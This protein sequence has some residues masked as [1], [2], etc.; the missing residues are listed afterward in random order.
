MKS[1]QRKRV[2]VEEAPP[3][4]AAVLDEVA[5]LFEKRFEFRVPPGETWTLPEA[6]LV[7]SSPAAQQPHADLQRLKKDLNEVKGRLSDKPLDVWHEHTAATNRTGHVVGHVRRVAG[8]ELCTQAWCKFHELLAGGL[9]V[10]PPS[11]LRRGGGRINSVHLCEAPGAFIC[12]LNHY[13]R[14]HQ[15]ACKL[16]WLA[17]TLNPFHESNTCGSM[18]PDARLILHTAARWCFG[19]DDTGDAM[20]LANLRRLQERARDELGDGAHLVTADGSFDCQGN[21]GEQEACVAPLV[22]CETVTALALLAPGGSFVLKLF[23]LFEHSSAC[24]LFL[25]V[26]TFQEVH[27]VKPATSKA[28]NSELYVVCLGFR[29]RDTFPPALLERL[30][31]HVGPDVCAHTALFPAARLPPSFTQ[32]LL[33]CATM[34]QKLQADTILENLW[35]FENDAGEERWAHIEAVREAAAWFYTD[36]YDVQPLARRDWLMQRPP[37]GSGAP[38]FQSYSGKGKQR[39]VGTYNQRKELESLSWREKVMQGYFEPDMRTFD[40]L[41]KID[42]PSRDAAREGECDGADERSEDPAE[43]RVL[44]CSPDPPDES[45]FSVRHGPAL[46]RV[47]NSPFCDVKLLERLNEARAKAAVVRPANAVWLSGQHREGSQSAAETEQRVR[48]T[49]IKLLNGK[50]LRGVYYMDIGQQTRRASVGQTLC[51]QLNPMDDVIDNSRKNKS[52]STDESSASA[53]VHS[54]QPDSACG[55]GPSILPPTPLDTCSATR[56][57]VLIPKPF[58]GVLSSPLLYDGDVLFQQNLVDGLQLMFSRLAEGD[59]LVLPLPAALTRFSAG[60]IFA[61]SQCFCRL[62]FL[63]LSPSS[64][65]IT[66][67][68]LCAGLRHPSVYKGVKEFI[69][70]LQHAVSNAGERCG[71]G[72]GDREGNVRQQVLEFVPI[73]VLL[74]EPLYTFLLKL[75]TDTLQYR[76]G[77]LLQLEKLFHNKI[78]GLAT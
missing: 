60:I 41:L 40:A 72:R 50:E 34:F 65:H 8:A 5:Q 36:H 7:F 28:G 9:P 10:L 15:A 75:N 71:D 58:V 35:L 1:G 24:L 67:V 11:A 55:G 45:T 49:L 42:A 18:I 51:A 19:A 57:T 63:N 20:C 27:V 69:S 29:G 12:S 39:Q 17:T 6:R 68:L 38:P 2:R 13:L 56:D 33:A 22:F 37:R 46:R 44:E 52:Q 61:L 70:V 3:T 43:E 25:L 66:T 77:L 74:R 73:E 47:A 48:A 21:P 59:C 53:V 4:N 64:F 14:T 26:C 76:L 78:S 32:Q 16:C 62:S 54:A 31:E 30:E 23:T